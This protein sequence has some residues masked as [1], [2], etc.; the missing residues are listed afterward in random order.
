MVKKVKQ[1]QKQTQKQNVIVN[2][3]NKIPAKR[4][5]GGRAIPTRPSQPAH[6]THTSSVIYT[7]PLPMNDYS[8][9]HYNQP[10]QQIPA[11]FNNIPTIRLPLAETTPAIHTDSFF[12]PIP[13]PISELTAHNDYEN[14]PLINTIR[15]VPKLAEP[16]FTNPMM[17]EMRR[18][19]FSESLKKTPDF[20]KQPEVLSPFKEQLKAKK[21]EIIDK[22]PPLNIPLPRDRADFIGNNPMY[23]TPLVAPE[24][25]KVLNPETGRLIK[26][27]GTTYNRIFGKGN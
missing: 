18:K 7:Q 3:H 17:E 1:K 24:V 11:V 10:Q 25:E 22:R 5:S 19:N 20:V 8:P 21:E 26:K 27:G 4:R 15:P 9:I 23:Y 6:S 16:I 12:T 2:I 14:R 13:S